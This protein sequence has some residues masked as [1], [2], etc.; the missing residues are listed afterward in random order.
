MCDFKNFSDFEKMYEEYFPK[1]YNYI[2]FR[3]LNKEQT[4]DLV[5]EIFLKVT[6]KIFS[7]DASKASFNTWIFVIAKNTL[8]DY[9][10]R[11]KKCVSLDDSTNSVLITVDFEEQYKEIVNEDRK[12]LYKALSQLDDRTRQVLYLKYFGELNNRE[13]SKVTGINEST[14]ST[15]FVRGKK[16]MKELL[17]GMEVS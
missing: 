4:E 10:R 8:T 3:L 6:Q 1:I 15:I 5:S 11:Q 16:K 7:F 13:I 12:I 17:I 14:V 2:F 9:F